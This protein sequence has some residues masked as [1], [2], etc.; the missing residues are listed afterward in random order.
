MIQI[1]TDSA[2]DITNAEAKNLGVYIV[3]INIEFQDGNCPQETLED[4]ELFYQKLSVSDELPTTSQP[5]PDLYLKYFKEAKSNNDDVLVITLSSGLS[6]I[7]SAVNI[8]KEL[9]DYD[10]IFV[11]DSHQAIGGQRILTEQAIKFRKLGYKVE[12]IISELEVLRDRITVNGM[13]DTLTY[14]RKGGRI[15]P[16]LA[17]VGN[18][19]RIKPIIVLEDKIIKMMGKAMGREAGKKLV[20]KRF[21]SH[22]PDENYPFYF[23]YSSNRD[24]GIQFM[25]ETMELYPFL[26]KFNPK[27]L[28]VNGVIGTHLG[29]N[30]IGFA[31]VMKTED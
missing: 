27:L 25:K 19:L 29:T 16:S 5:S 11:L 20:Y 21:E 9:C 1:I 13:I 26:E 6:G 8:A 24:L 30:G 28:P 7:L 31:Y 15:P 10:R 17:A 2:S 14:L 23:V 18:T 22:L 12:D 4:F 3:P